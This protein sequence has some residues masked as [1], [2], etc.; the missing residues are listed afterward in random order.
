[1]TQRGLPACLDNGPARQHEPS[2][3]DELPSIFSHPEG[4]TCPSL[5]A[6]R[7]GEVRDGQLVKRIW[8][9]NLV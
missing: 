5:S 8:T 1:M 6:N 3:I 2:V 4:M 9:P 7:D